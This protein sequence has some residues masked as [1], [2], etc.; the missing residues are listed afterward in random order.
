MG[1]PYERFS[2]RIEQELQTDG[3]ESLD[4]GFYE[5]QEHRFRQRRDTGKRSA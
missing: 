1:V 3:V 2:E 4:R 5:A